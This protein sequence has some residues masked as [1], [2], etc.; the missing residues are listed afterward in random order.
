MEVEGEFRVPQNPSLP[1]DWLIL[2]VDIVLTIQRQLNGIQSLFIIRG[3]LYLNTQ[4]SSK[5][6]IPS[7]RV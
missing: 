6:A 4:S 3:T 1:S 2:Q 5:L 7:R